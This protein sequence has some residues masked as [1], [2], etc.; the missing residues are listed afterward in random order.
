VR[1]SYI[2]VSNGANKIVARFRERAETVSTQFS[3]QFHLESR[4]WRRKSEQRPIWAAA[5]SAGIRGHDIG[6]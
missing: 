3:S 1:T 6:L 5:E 2:F 4:L